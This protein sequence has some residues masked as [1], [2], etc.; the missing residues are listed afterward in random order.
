MKEKFNP[1]GQ[2]DLFRSELKSIINLQHELCLLSEK[3]NWKKFEEDFAGYFPAKVGNPALPSR[4][5]LGVFY[6]KYAHKLSD[7]EAV[8]RWTENPYWQYFCGLEYFQHEPPFHPTSLIKWR[9]RLGEAG[10]EK[11]LKEL[12]VVGVE[13]ETIE[14]KDLEKVI[15][16]TTVQEKA[17]TF[18]TDAKLQHRAR[19]LLLKEA[20]KHGLKLRQTYLRVGKKALFMGHRYAAAKQMKRARKQFKLVKRYLGC[21][22]RDIQR[23]LENLP[24]LRTHFADLLEKTERL[25]TQKKD[26]KNK[27]YSLHAPEV[28]CI[29]KGKAHK[30]YEFGVKA[31]IATTHKSNF[32]VGIKA[33]PGNPYDGHTLK[34]ALDQV[35]RLT[36]IRPSE[37]YVD[38]GYR[39]H[40]E[41]K[42]KI[43]IARTK[44]ALKTY[45]LRKDMRRRNAIE[46]VIGHL[47][48]DGHLGRNYLKGSEGDKINALFSGI[49][50]NFRLILRKL[51]LLWLY[52]LWVLYAHTD[53]K[54]S[55]FDLVRE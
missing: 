32:V 5:V 20:K 36:G 6:L 24:E 18:P 39:K 13:T 17:I 14:V 8:A 11:I 26:D 27:L 54:K 15:V 49:G 50:H 34:E 1:K 51:R 33:L 23:Q 53:R 7:E 47:K 55:D 46:P 21:V 16:D 42:T 4:L 9:K 29:G 22:Y 12:I 35:E 37:G 25:L 28:E 45:A 52:I 48:S 38:L 19:V 31:S 43:H 41:D 40:D 2:K 44:V 30:K 10:C 3:I